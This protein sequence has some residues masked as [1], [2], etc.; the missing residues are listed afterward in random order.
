VSE[1]LVNATLLV[2]L[3]TFLTLTIALILALAWVDGTI[4]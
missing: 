4:S 3:L 2:I 1:R